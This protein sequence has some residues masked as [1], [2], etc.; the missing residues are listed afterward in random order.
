MVPLQ[1]QLGNGVRS[2][3]QAVRV[4]SGKEDDGKGGAGSSLV[5]GRRGSQSEVSDETAY[6]DPLCIGLLWR[7]I[8]E[9]RYDVR[10]VFDGS[11]VTYPTRRVTHEDN[12]DAKMGS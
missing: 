3:D 7:T 1:I 2:P 4:G 6:P 12:G 11:T 10:S 5:S 8:A 9:S